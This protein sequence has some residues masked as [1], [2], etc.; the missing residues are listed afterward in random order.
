MGSSYGLGLDVAHITC[1]HLIGWDPVTWLHLTAR[2]AET[3]FQGC[4]Q[5]EERITGIRY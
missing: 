2:E 1:S 5:R 3:V 4:A